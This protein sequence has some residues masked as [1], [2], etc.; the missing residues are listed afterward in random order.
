M[1]EGSGQLSIVVAYQNKDEAFMAFD[2]AIVGGD[3]VYQAITPK[4]VQHAGNGLIGACG[5][6]S[7]INAIEAL[8][9][10]K[11]T[12][13]N[14]IAELREL[15]NN[16]NDLG[17]E[18]LFAFPGK[19]LALVQIDYSVVELSSQFMAIGIGAPYALGYLEAFNPAEIGKKEL[20]KAV[21]IAA[22]YST[23]VI[24]PVKILRCG[25]GK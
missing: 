20:M 5:S 18:V 25:A 15:K 21:E 24:K 6:W 2:S 7:V 3:T 22:K 8:K 16:D 9:S 4:A 17:A 19:P 14:V 12:P 10:T 13:Y 1:D 23:G 11:C